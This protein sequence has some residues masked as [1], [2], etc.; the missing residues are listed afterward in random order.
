MRLILFF[1]FSLTIQPLP[2]RTSCYLHSKRLP[3]ARN[4]FSLSTHF[5]LVHPRHLNPICFEQASPFSKCLFAKSANASI[6]TRLP[7]R[8]PTRLIVS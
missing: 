4:Y 3:L 1:P 2:Y 8:P 5:R 6:N 7:F